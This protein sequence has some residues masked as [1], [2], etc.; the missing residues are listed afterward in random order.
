LSVRARDNPFRT[1]RT[2]RLTYRAPDFRWPELLARL[3]LLG[4][5][6]AIRGAQGSGKTTLLREL[7][8]R[9]GERGFEVRRL[10]PSLD[11][12]R[13]AAHQV[14]RLATAAGPGTALLLDGADRVGFPLYR[15]E[16]SV[17]LLRELAAELAPAPEL[18]SISLPELYS[19]QRGNLRCALRSLYDRFAER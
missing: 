11:E 18:A 9:L 4:G 3:E 10:R 7:G 1:E 16:T 19:R 15:C 14:R 17:D 12:P 6:G 13:L 5:R 8:E 2:D